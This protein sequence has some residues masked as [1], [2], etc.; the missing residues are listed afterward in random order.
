MPPSAKLPLVLKTPS[1]NE[2]EWLVR[3]NDLI[4]RMARL[5]TAVAGDAFAKGAAQIVAGEGTAALS[6]EG[7]IDFAKERARLTKDLKK[8]DDEVA[9]VDQKLNNK[10]FVA[11]APE[12][13]VQE[14]RDKRV[15][16]LSVRSKVQEALKRVE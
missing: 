13:V 16:H 11:K 5:E 7:F 3:H 10:D 14:L 15:E 6:L 9:R 4:L 12:D 2:R 8:A 1:A